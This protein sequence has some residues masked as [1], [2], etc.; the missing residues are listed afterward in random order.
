MRLGPLVDRIRR[1]ILVPGLLEPR[2]TLWPLKRRLQRRCERVECFPDRIA[3]RNLDRSIDRLAGMLSEGDQEDSV[4]IVTH[5]FG[6]WVARQAIARAPE[7]RV[8]ALVSVAPAMRPGLFIYALYLVSRNLIP[9]VAVIMDPSKA[10][11][12]VDC[13]DQVRRLVIWAKADECVRSID[14]HHVQ[15]IEV[16]RVLATHLSVVLQPSVLAKIERN[17]FP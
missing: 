6:D 3:F 15:G 1:I 4:G 5:S 11:A 12:N 8:T 14:L 9:E 13:D 16:E 17:L 2:V 10:E 7:H